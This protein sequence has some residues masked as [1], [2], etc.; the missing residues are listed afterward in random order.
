MASLGGQEGRARLVGVG[1]GLGA[2]WCQDKAFA[3]L[4]PAGIPARI[5]T[6]AAAA[7]S[8]RLSPDFI[9]YSG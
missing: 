2:A 3:A 5:P 8:W 4:A 6:E 1:R 9:G 7:G